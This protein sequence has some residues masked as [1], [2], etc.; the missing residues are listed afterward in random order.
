MSKKKYQ[1][2]IDQKN[3]FEIKKHKKWN[4][5]QAHYIKSYLRK[6]KISQS[7]LA[8]L[9][10]CSPQKIKRIVDG[11]DERLKNSLEHLETLAAITDISILDFVAYLTGLNPSQRVGGLSPN[12]KSMLEAF[13]KANLID[14][15]SFTENYCENENE[16]CF[17]EI[18][19]ILSLLPK[20]NIQSLRILSFFL[21]ESKNNLSAKDLN[22]KST[23]INSIFEAAYSKNGLASKKSIQ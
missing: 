9:L 11:T 8:E 12:E 5:K 7:K 6:N 21:L 13:N 2:N 18:I 4:D 16:Q 23:L 1:R 15:R 20:L 17:A 14:K 3:L 19:K 10:D 22:T